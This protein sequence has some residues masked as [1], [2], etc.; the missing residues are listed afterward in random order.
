MDV[1]QVL[2]EAR[3]SIGADRVFAEP[4]Q[5]N[6][7]TV[8]PAARVGGGGGGGGDESENGGS[9]A[10]FGLTAR[11]AG[12][13]VIR[14]DGSVGW[15]PMVDPNKVILGGQLVAIA[16]LVVLWL[17]ARSRAKAAARAG[18]AEAAIHRIGHRD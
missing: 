11:P 8:I 18:I 13:L 16:A 3:S 5:R 12:A 15:Q 2:N 10:G 6:G 14:D 4:Y 1:E 7:V 17:T 9:G